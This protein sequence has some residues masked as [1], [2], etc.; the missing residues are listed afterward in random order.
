MKPRKPIKIFQYCNIKFKDPNGDLMAVTEML[1]IL[2]EA[3]MR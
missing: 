2:C 1:E 3:R